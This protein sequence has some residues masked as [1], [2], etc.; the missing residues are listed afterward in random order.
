MQKD[1]TKGNA[2]RVLIQFSLPY[3]LSC[4]LQTFYGMAD[5]FITGQF[6]GADTISA[7]S[8]G[9]Q[10]MHMV[11]VIIVGLAMGSTVMI[12]QAVGEKN[13]KKAARTVGNTVTLFMTVSVL[14]TV[15]LLL[16][17]SGILRLVAV[18]AEAVPQTRIYLQICF[19]GIPFITAYNIIS[20]IYR[21]MGDSR[22]PMYFIAVACV[23]NIILDFVLIGGCSMGAAGAALGTVLS[24]TASVVLALL[25]IRRKSFGVSIRMEDLKP[26][27][28]AMGDVLRIGVPIALQ[29]GFIQVSFMIITIIANRRGV[30]AAAAVGIVEKIIS[31][32]FLVPSA[33]LSSISSIAAQNVGAQKYGRAV[34]TLRYGVTIAVSFGIIVSVICQFFSP[35]ILGMFTGDAVVVEMGTQYLKAYVFDCI[36]AGIHF[37]F[38]GFFCAYGFSGISFMQNLASIVLVRVPGAYLAS[39]FFPETLYPMGLAAPGGSLLSAII[40]IVVF[41]IKKDIFLPG[42]HTAAGN[43]SK[44]QNNR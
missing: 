3:L 34:T 13:S 22:S 33:M 43:T 27:K 8:I 15:T 16:A 9:S 32:F 12:S 37:C 20:C 18:P 28:A 23:L 11:T 41:L 19:A 29:D 39:K 24:Q 5:L 36:V 35:Q 44:K 1:L 26:D 10:I 17:T 38:S 14:L 40:C 6:N 25:A 31:F 2:L 4:F 30:S 7:V 21:G 42:K